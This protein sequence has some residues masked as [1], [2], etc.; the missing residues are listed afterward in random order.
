VENTRKFFSLWS[1]ALRF[2]SLTAILGALE[3]ELKKEETAAF[4]IEPVQ[5]RE[6]L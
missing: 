4:I 1:R 2:P 5:V 6:G 3:R